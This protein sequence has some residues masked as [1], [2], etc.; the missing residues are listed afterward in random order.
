MYKQ[1]LFLLF[2]FCMVCSCEKD[3]KP[4]LEKTPISVTTD[5]FHNSVDKVIEVMVHDI[6]SPPVASRVFAYPNIAAYEIIAQND[7]AY[8]SL[9]KQIKHLEGIPKAN[10][11]TQINF[12]LAAL[13]AHIDLSKQLIFSENRIETYRDSLYAVWSEQNPK[14]FEDSK[15]YGLEVSGF[16]ASWMKTDNYAQT[17]T[18]PKF[19][20]NTKDESRWQPT[21]PSYMDG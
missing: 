2:V 8:H 11:E 21:P 5:D 10:S 14:E 9:K 15:A 18:M 12:S 16:I 19:S 1:I 6:F 7:T 17:R 13:V 20:V 4:D 3:T